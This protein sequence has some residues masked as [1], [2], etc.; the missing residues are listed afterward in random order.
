M[1]TGMKTDEGI[2]K[3]VVDSLYWD[4][5]VDASKVAVTVDSGIVT[6]SGSVSSYSERTAAVENA[7][8]IA[9]VRDVINQL[10][11][12]YRKKAPS[13]SEIKSN[14]E[15]SFTW[16]NDLYPYNINI[17]VVAGWVTLE[18]TIDAFWK[19]DRAED[20]AFGMRGVTGVTNKVAVVPTQAIAD[21]NIAESIINALDRNVN[22]NV[23]DINVAV[24]NGTVALNGT[25]PSWSAKRAAYDTARYTLGVKEVKDQIAVRLR[26]DTLQG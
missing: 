7:W 12:G 20:L 5:R 13:D 26:A 9:G 19:K 11:V 25:V 17:S 14:T 23:D 16:D 1:A 10:K 4:S 6:L 21:E 8:V 3:D 22:V 15:N 18:G 24:E 2:A